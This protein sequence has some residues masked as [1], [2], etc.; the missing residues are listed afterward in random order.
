MFCSLGT[1]VGLIL[2]CPCWQIVDWHFDIEATK[3]YWCMSIN[4][5]GEEN[6]KIHNEHANYTKSNGK[7]YGPLAVGNW[8]TTP[9]VLLMVFYIFFDIMSNLIWRSKYGFVGFGYFAN[10]RSGG[11]ILVKLLG[12]NKWKFS[13]KNVI[14]FLPILVVNA[15]WLFIYNYIILWLASWHEWLMT[16]D[17]VCEECGILRRFRGW[18]VTENNRKNF[19]NADNKK[20][21]EGVG[22]N[23][24]LLS[25]Y[26]RIKRN[27]WSLYKFF[28]IPEKLIQILMAFICL[29]LDE[30]KGCNDDAEWKIL[31]SGICGIIMMFSTVFYF[32]RLYRAV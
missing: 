2:G 26:F 16:V 5:I 27:R 22:G 10:E 13:W 9:F 31:L 7:W 6:I 17:E 21:T 4:G 24:N 20:K 11:D 19:T 15:I 30:R 23:Y 25:K 28:S 1:I 3:E 29:Y 14:W 8:F 32:I 18:F 12:I